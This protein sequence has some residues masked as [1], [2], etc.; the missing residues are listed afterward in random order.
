MRSYKKLSLLLIGVL[1]ITS[2]FA[3][4][5]STGGCSITKPPE[6]RPVTLQYW[7]VWDSQAQIGP[8]IQAY[9]ATHPTIKVQY[10]QLRY[11]EYE[12]ELLEAWADDRGP[13]I[14]AIP[15][16]WLKEYESRLKPM[17]A[18]VKI[19]V[20]EVKGSIKKE[21][22]TSLQE[23][24]GYSSD[25]I[26]SRFVD[27]VYN[28]V[29][30]DG[31]IYGLPYSLDTMV[32][33]YNSKLLSAA[34][35]AEP[36]K[37]FSELIEQTPKLTKVG[38]DNEIYQAAVA[39]GGADNI[40]GFLGIISNLL[41]QT[42]VNIKGNS[43]L[44]LRDDTSASNLARDLGFYTDFMRVGLSS[45][46]WSN[47]LP[48]AFDMFAEGKLAYFFGYSYHADALRQKGTPFE[49]RITNFP[50]TPGSQG[51]K[52]YS[53]YWVNVVPAK[54]KN[55]DA[56]WNFIQSTASADLVKTYLKNTKKP[57]A[58]RSLIK[59][60][61]ADPELAVFASQVLTADNWYNGYDYNK[62]EQYFADF[63]NDINS[64]KIDL[65]KTTDLRALVD[66][67]NQTYQSKND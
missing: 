66:R 28:N 25:D 37:D 13:D 22:V 33:F 35:I 1:M 64:G 54:S 30:R 50:Q 38:Q 17:P 21:V 18:S 52:Y 4:K 36:M 67:I 23:V 44:P 34:G 46:S 53:D 62:A 48:N 57:T 32:T 41:L 24:K 9:Q 40:P 39:M 16:S 15:A 45:Y 59:E 11:E 6:A 31:K 63:I 12:N 5:N 49:W 47:S 10:R 8:L 43:F 29:V 20:Q 58:L 3:C 55:S 19:P 56:A 27:V 51:T 61:T 65:N 26:K 2:G 42:N 14:F 7:G 60:Q